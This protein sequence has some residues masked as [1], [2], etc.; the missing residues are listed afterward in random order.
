MDDTQNTKLN[1]AGTAQFLYHAQSDGLHRAETRPIAGQPDDALADAD[2]LRFRAFV[3][4]R[5]GLDFTEDKRAMLS[6][7]LLQMLELTHSQNLDQLYARLALC[8]STSAVWDQLIGALTV[9]ETYFFRNTNHFDALVKHILPGIIAEREHGNRRIRIWSAGCATGEEPYSL[10]IL[11]RETIP[12]I[13]SWNISILAT[14]INR[15]ALKKAREGKYSAWSFRGVEKRVQATYFRQSDNQYVISDAIK[16]MVAF[17]C[18]NLVGDLFPSLTNNTNAMDLIV[19]RN[20]TIYFSE[21]VTRAVIAKFQACLVNN[22]WL[23]PGPSEPNML[24]YGDFQARNFPGTVIYQKPG[25]ATQAK[26][27]LTFVPAS[28][29]AFKPVAPA[30]PKPARVKL[31]PPDP[32]QRALELIQAG[33]ADQ[34]LA[35]LH[36]KIDQSAN[37]APAYFMLGKI[38]ANRGNLEEAQHW[39][40]RAIRLDKL[41]PEPYYTLS[42]IYEQ[43]GLLDAAVEALKKTMYLDRE[44]ILAHYNLAQIYRHQNE[45]ELARRELQTVQRLL[46]GIAPGAIVP[47]GDG[48]IVGRLA[49]LVDGELELDN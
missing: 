36:E 31:A 21:A 1:D 32:Y 45:K 20:V 37:F 33:Q 23:I 42:L 43:H 40:E 39:C 27:A 8:A 30:P 11:L 6:R 46:R 15:D 25:G 34:A 16:K 29:A 41:H 24:Y 13:E 7:G 18:L 35:K 14:D 4:D 17:D 28:S 10:A 48:L 47:E 44:F 2:Y 38:Y 49:E 12:N 5:T 26:S 19:C 3:L 9:G 22:G